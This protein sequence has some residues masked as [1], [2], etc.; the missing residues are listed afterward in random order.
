MIDQI[1]IS[2]VFHLDCELFSLN[3]GIA[4]ADVIV[5][6]TCYDTKSY[7]TF[8][9]VFLQVTSSLVL[10]SEYLTIRFVL[11]YKLYD[12]MKNSISVNIFLKLL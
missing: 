2:N 7:S 1:K 8:E 6:R 12:K 11:S 5:N 10:Q 4:T 3:C 9:N